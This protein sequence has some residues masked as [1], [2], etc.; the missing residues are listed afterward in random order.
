MRKF[1]LLL[2]TLAVLGMSTAGY[3]TAY[4][5]ELREAAQHALVADDG[6][7]E[8]NSLHGSSHSCHI[9]AHLIALP[10]AGLLPPTPRADRAGVPLSVGSPPAVFLDH[11][12]RPPR[13][14]A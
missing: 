11:P 14:A 6:H 7:D 5:S 3:A 1:V 8:S 9:G 12:L 2:V 13:A 10:S 4:G